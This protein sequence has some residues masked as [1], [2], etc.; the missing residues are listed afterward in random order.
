MNI[1]KTPTNVIAISARTGGESTSADFVIIQLTEDWIDRLKDRL[2]CVEKSKDNKD[3]YDVRFWDSPDVWAV[4]SD[5]TEEAYLEEELQAHE[6]CYLDIAD[7][8]IDELSGIDQQLDSETMC[9][10]D[11]W[12][13]KYTG[14]GKHSGDEFWTSCINADVI[15]ANYEKM[16]KET[17]VQ[18]CDATK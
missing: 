3:F 17:A 14:Y 5:E 15:V 10:N 2:K 4:F 1:S 12:E 11:S 13:F 8:E 6:F 18:V 16:I 9:I 7:K